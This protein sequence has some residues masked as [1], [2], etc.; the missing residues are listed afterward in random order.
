M[1]GME[2]MEGL[3]TAN[4]W[5]QMDWKSFHTRWLKRLRDRF[6]FPAGIHDEETEPVQA[7]VNHGAWLVMCPE[8]NG[9]EYAW[10]EG[11]FFCCSCKNSYLKHNYRRLVFPA[12]RQAIERLLMVRSLDN[13]NWNHI[14]TVA[15]LERENEEHADKLLSPAGRG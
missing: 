12:E 5:F 1:E 10:E 14:E 11:Y 7:F 13:R 9:A 3:I 2:I 8:C 15:D 6:H 4:T